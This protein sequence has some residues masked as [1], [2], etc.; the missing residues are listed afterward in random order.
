MTQHRRQNLVVIGTGMA[1]R[2]FV[3]ELAANPGASQFNIAVVGGM[4]EPGF[5]WLHKGSRVDTD[6]WND[7][8]SV[9]GALP[10]GHDVMPL[11]KTRT[12]RI[13]RIKKRVE[14]TDG[15][16]LP[17][18][19]VVFATGASPVL[20]EIEGNDLRG[21]VA[22][23]R[24]EDLTA[25]KEFAANSRRATVLGG[26]L[27]G[28]KAAEACV[29]AGV[30]TTLLEYEDRLMPRQLNDKKGQINSY[31]V[32]MGIKVR[33]D[34]RPKCINGNGQVACIRLIGDALIPSDLVVVC[35]DIRPNDQL[36]AAAGIPVAAEGGIIVDSRLR[37]ADPD[38]FAIGECASFNGLV[39]GVVSPGFSM[40]AVLAG[41]LSGRPKRFRVPDTTIKLRRLGVDPSR[42][43]LPFD[44][45]PPRPVTFHR[46]VIDRPTVF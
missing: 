30:E 22:Y 24:E 6:T 23:Q 7:D 27:L 37:T 41:N 42:P 10:N 15:T 2:K 36:A 34:A 25:V 11:L 46:N 40:A 32:S 31:L 9:E 13:D 18:D 14:T 5:D 33:T 21:V 8:G 38:I 26:G 12:R 35:A 19:T 17:Y 45:R 44:T 3:K 39:C 4:S 29:A 43:D 28:L 20:P 16:F 1:A